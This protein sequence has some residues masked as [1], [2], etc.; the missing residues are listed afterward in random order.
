MECEICCM[1]AKKYVQC[2]GC[3]H[4]VCIACAKKCVLG[5]KFLHMEC[6]YC[7]T[8]WTSNFVYETFDQKWLNGE[9]SA[10][11]ETVL[12]DMIKAY[13]PLYQDMAALYI[14]FYKLQEQQAP[15]DV[16]RDFSDQ[17][18]GSKAVEKKMLL[19][20]CPKDGCKGLV[21]YPGTCPI[22][23]TKVCTHCR[24]MEKENH[25]CDPTIVENVVCLIEECKPCPVCYSPITK[26]DGCSQMFCTVESCHTLFDWNTGKI[27]TKGHNPHYYEWMR[28]TGQ[29][30]PQR[31][32]VAE[33][34]VVCGRNGNINL[35][36]LLKTIGESPSRPVWNTLVHDVEYNVT[37]VI[38][39]L[40]T[41]TPS[42]S[43]EIY[44]KYLIDYIIDRRDESTTRS[45]IM[46]QRVAWELN[47]ELLLILLAYK[48]MMYDL[49]WYV[50]KSSKNHH[51]HE[52][53][54]MYREIVAITDRE[55]G[56]WQKRTGQKI[57][58]FYQG[59]L[60]DISYRSDD[61]DRK[62]MWRKCWS[63]MDGRLYLPNFKIPWKP[64]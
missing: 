38:E 14:Q 35:P 61:N 60:L 15:E 4:Y 9:F 54:A 18:S 34:R 21:Y 17:L 40:Q 56:K 45:L 48:E 50:Q 55:L 36:T 13:L 16:L 28:K 33:E 47:N 27:E 31:A 32:G 30:L 29:L 59:D 5:N 39:K 37:F 12:W 43:P 46:K 51:Q 64:C 41:M 53:L 3:T 63:L 20:K 62:V 44:K 6:V 2:P 10:H 52:L 42:H 26:I 11:K 8:Q 25:H 58:R 19:C 23:Q 22:C 1:K 24:E 49:F 57:Y 7:K